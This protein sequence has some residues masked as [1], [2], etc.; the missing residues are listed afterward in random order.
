MEMKKIMVLSV[1]IFLFLCIVSLAGEMGKRLKNKGLHV[2][3]LTDKDKLN[4]QINKLE[5]AVRQQWIGDVEKILSE[6]Y[7]EADPIITKNS[8]REEL[9]VLFSSFSQGRSLSTR[10][11]PQTGWRETATMDFYIQVVKINITGNKATVDC[12]IGLYSAG[13]DNK[14][15]QESLSFVLK[16][17]KWLLVGSKNLIGFLKQ[18]SKDIRRETGTHDLWDQGMIGTKDDFTSSHLL[19]PVTLFEYEGTPVPRF[20]M[21]ESFKW[22]WK[23]YSPYW[24]PINVMSYPYGILA[25]VLVTPGETRN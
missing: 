25:D 21:S 10:E 13:K 15:I 23:Y 4:L 19:V 20:N 9:E 17:I 6:N 16:D 2:S 12:E 14:K 22:F 7:V 11:N 24:Y 5:Q 8:I 3:E 1:M 18:A